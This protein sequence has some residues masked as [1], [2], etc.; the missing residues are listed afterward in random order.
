LNE[1][2][3]EVTLN[4]LSGGRYISRDHLTGNNA[5]R[6][7]EALKHGAESRRR[8]RHTVRAALPGIKAV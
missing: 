1:Y 3:K 2:V 5:A 7:H 4:Y 8:A 6:Y